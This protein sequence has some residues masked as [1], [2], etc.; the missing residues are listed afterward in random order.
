METQ[1]PKNETRVCPCDL[2]GFC[3]E[4]TDEEIIEFVKVNKECYALIVQRYEARLARYIRRIS[5]VPKESVEDILQTVF[6]KAYANIDSFD[7]RKGFSSWIYGITHNETINHWRKNKR[8]SSE[9]SLDSN[10]FLK[11]VI[12]DKRDLGAEVSQKIDGQKMKELLGRISPHHRDALQLRYMEEFSYREISKKMKKPVG[13][14][15]T[16]INRGKKILQEELIKTGF[17][18]GISQRT[19]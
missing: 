5:S 11:N 12:P 2:A 17:S 18:I 10:E 1:L 13:T 6:V 16:L 8:A 7:T 9:I 15:G 4:R 14:V 3:S 19:N